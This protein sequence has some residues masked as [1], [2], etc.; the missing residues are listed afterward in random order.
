VSILMLEVPDS[1][2]QGGDHNPSRVSGQ[3]KQVQV[4]NQRGW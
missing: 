4:L 1:N 2:Q 3:E